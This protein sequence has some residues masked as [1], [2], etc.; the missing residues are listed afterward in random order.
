MGELPVGDQ[1]RAHPGPHGAHQQRARVCPE[2]AG[3]VLPPRVLAIAAS[4]GGGAA[5]LPQDPRGGLPLRQLRRMEENAQCRHRR[6]LHGVGEG[7]GDPGLRVPGRGPWGRL[8]LLGGDRRHRRPVGR[9]AERPRQHDVPRRLLGLQRV[10]LHLHHEPEHVRG[11]VR[12]LVTVRPRFIE[13]VLCRQRSRASG[14]AVGSG[15]LPPEPSCRYSC[16]YSVRRAQ[17]HYCVCDFAF[18]EASS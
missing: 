9:G 17:R 15:R 11:R 16:Q 10:H 8:L 13:E 1:L 6:G 4:G 2:A 14:L 7:G 12:L 5:G 18:C 3:E